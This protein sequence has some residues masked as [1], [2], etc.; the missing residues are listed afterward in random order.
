MK[1]IS[2][3]ILLCL[4]MFSVVVNMSAGGEQEEEKRGCW[5]RAFRIAGKILGAPVAILGFVGGV[6]VVSSQGAF[7][8]LNAFPVQI[9]PPSIVCLTEQD[10]APLHE[11]AFRCNE[12][13]VIR[14]RKN[15]YSVLARANC[16]FSAEGDSIMLPSETPIVL[17]DLGLRVAKERGDSGQVKRCASTVVEILIE[18]LREEALREK[19]D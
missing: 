15:G 16:S 6:A 11:D 8:M 5:T 19:N 2:K 13:A 7:S 3:L 14:H 9:Q 12:D 4:M 17:S 18:A 1:S 10:R